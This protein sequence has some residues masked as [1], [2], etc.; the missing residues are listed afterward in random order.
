LERYRTAE[1][2][3]RQTASG[4]PLLPCESVE[5][6]I[7]IHILLKQIQ[8]LLKQ[9]QI[10]L[11]QIQILLAAGRDSETRARPPRARSEP[12]IQERPPHARQVTR[13]FGYVRYDGLPFKPGPAPSA[14]QARVRPTRVPIR[15]SPHRPAQI[16]RNKG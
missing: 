1:R 11:K 4:N 15:A 8:I 12:T 6:L 9:I 7:Q 3:P 14:T 16:G 10:L 2:V 5:L 13:A